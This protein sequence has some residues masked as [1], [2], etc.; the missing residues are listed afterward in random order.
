MKYYQIANGKNQLRQVFFI[1][2]AYKYRYYNIKVSHI[3]HIKAFGRIQ[4]YLQ[5]LNALKFTISLVLIIRQ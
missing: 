1:L 4:V 2:Y 3:N 5:L